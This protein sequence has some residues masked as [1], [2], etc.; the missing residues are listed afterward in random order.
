VVSDLK[1]QIA[2]SKQKFSDN[3]LM[4]LRNTAAFMNAALHAEESVDLQDAFSDKPLSFVT[5]VLRPSV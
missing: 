2:T 3:Q 4:W 5:K 1:T